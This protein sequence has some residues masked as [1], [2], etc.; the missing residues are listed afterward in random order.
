MFLSDLV[1][2]RRYGLFLQLL[3]LMLPRYQASGTITQTQKRFIFYVYKCIAPSMF[4][5][6]VMFKFESSTAL[7]PLFLFHFIPILYFHQNI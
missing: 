3:S 5:F 7:P 2:M 6:M 4:T 1:L